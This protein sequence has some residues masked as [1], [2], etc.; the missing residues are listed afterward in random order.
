MDKTLKCKDCKKDFV[1]NE[2]EQKFYADKGFTEPRRCPGCRALNKQKQQTTQQT[3][4]SSNDDV[5]SNGPRR[6]PLDAQRASPVPGDEWVG[7]GD[8]IPRQ[9]RRGRSRPRRERTERDDYWD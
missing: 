2:G 3:P 9:E 6:T 4:R 1:F 8:P 5:H 7:G